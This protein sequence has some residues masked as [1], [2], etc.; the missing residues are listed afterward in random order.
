MPDEPDAVVAPA[1]S[2]MLVVSIDEKSHV[3]LKNKFLCVQELFG[4]EKKPWL[5]LFED[6]SA[7]IFRLT[8]DNY[9]YN[10]VPVSGLVL[11]IFEVPG[12]YNPV[13][14]GTTITLATPYSKNK[15][16]VTIIDTDVNGGTK[17]GYVAMIEIVALMIGDIVQ[18]YSEHAYTNP[19]QVKA[20]MFLNKGQP[21]SLY[22]PGSSTDVLLFEK[23]RILF[24]N[25]IIE[26][27]YHQTASS[28]FSQGFGIPLIE[29]GI[30]VRSCIGKAKY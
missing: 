10:H 20:G 30:K 3:F 25:D 12:C 7:A 23:D 6:G 22:R 15:R 4:K 21:K 27:M 19:Q 28:R 5:S 8:P 2:K 16:I 11:D 13:N 1:D 17:V 29:T 14:P 26:N 9:H 18:C 24:C